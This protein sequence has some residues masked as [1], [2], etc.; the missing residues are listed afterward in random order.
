MWVRAGT[1]SGQGLN[2]RM[3]LSQGK[4]WPGPESEFWAGTGPGP[5]PGEV[6]SLDLGL[7]C[8]YRTGTEPGLSQMSEQDWARD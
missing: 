5:E 2:L 3:N 1:E 4:D 6:Q 8:G 7:R